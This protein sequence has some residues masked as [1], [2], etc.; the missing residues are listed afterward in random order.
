MRC[1]E[2]LST[3]VRTSYNELTE[4]ERTLV[5]ARL[6]E[7]STAYRQIEKEGTAWTPPDFA[8]AATRVAYLYEYVSFNAALLAKLFEANPDLVQPMFNHP[9][10]S[11]ACLGGGPGSDIVG[12]HKYLEGHAPSQFKHLSAMILDRCDAWGNEW[13]K[14]DMDGIEDAGF[15]L[16]SA[17]RPCDVNASTSLGYVRHFASIN[18]IT[19]LFF[20]SELMASKE[21]ATPF[22]S[23]AL[24]KCQDGTLLFYVDNDRPSMYEWFDNL[25]ASKQWAILRSDNGQQVLPSD[26]QKRILEELDLGISRS[27][28]VQGYVR[29]AFARKGG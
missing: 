6:E 5:P 26:E 11:V 28:R 25:L 2:V 23:G 1:F 20:L 16:T 3:V 14:I 7:L 18:L 27:P 15:R 10:T 19:N 22:L 8:D 21:Q 24:E 4:E 17:H 12:L 29:W 13:I 9:K